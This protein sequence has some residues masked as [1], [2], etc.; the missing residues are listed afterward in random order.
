MKEWLARNEEAPSIPLTAD[1]ALDNLY[2]ESLAGTVSGVFPMH[3]VAI[4]RTGRRL[5]LRRSCWAAGGEVEAIGVSR[6][7]EISI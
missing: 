2:T 6:T 5:G 1:P 7:G 4:A 3:V